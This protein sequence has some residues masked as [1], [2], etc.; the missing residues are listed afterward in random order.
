MLEGFAYCSC[1]QIWCEN[2]CEKL[3]ILCSVS[4][5]FES[6]LHKML[7]IIVKNMLLSEQQ[8]FYLAVAQLR[9]LCVLC[10]LPQ[11]QCIDGVSSILCTATLVKA[12]NVVDH[13]FLLHKLY[14]Y[15]IPTFSCS[16]SAAI[17]IIGRVSSL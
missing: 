1:A 8:S 14:Y 11:K 16:Y 3:Q 2:K 17:F 15:N 10:P 4:K 13:S 5:L 9:I 12:F 7:S 6:I